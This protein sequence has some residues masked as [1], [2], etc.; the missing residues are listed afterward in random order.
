M[1]FSNKQIYL[2]LS[3]TLVVCSCVNLRHVEE[4]SKT[5]IEAIEK[6]ESLPQNFTKICIEDCIQKNIGNFKIHQ[7]ACECH[8]NERADSITQ[9]IYTVTRDYFY[10]L[11][12]L[13]DNK[14]TNYQTANLTSTLATGDF[15][16]V[17]LNEADVNAYSKVSTLLLRAFTDGYRRK[18]MKD[19]ITQSHEPLEVLLHFLELNLSGNLNGK[20]EVQKSSIKDFYFDHVSNK[21]LSSYER[22][23][24]AEDYFRRIAEIDDKQKELKSYSLVLSEIAAGHDTLYANINNLKDEKVKGKLTRLSRRLKRSI[25]SLYKPK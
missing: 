13:A 17:K 21:K 5:S 19:Y 7:T 9:V 12:D 8:Q 20:L 11:V 14:L 18:K 10:G 16:P 4:F 1:S 15:G 23:K 2:V 3:L 6:Y 25:S 22:T 24:F